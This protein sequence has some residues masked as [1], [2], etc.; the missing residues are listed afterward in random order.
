MNQG[1]HFVDLLQW[2]LGPVDTVV[3]HCVTAAHDLA[4]E[5]LCV[6][7]LTFASGALGI[8]NVSTAIYP[9]FADRLEISGTDGTAIVEAGE[10]AVWHLKAERGETGPFGET[11]RRSHR[12]EGAA[13]TRVPFTQNVAGHRAQ[14]EDLLE[15]IE[16]G[17][18]PAV[19]GQEAR[20]SLAIV[21]AIYASARSG[22]R[23][24]LASAE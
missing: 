12:D 17:R 1:I 5:D 14:L 20:K 24:T 23:V 8:V 6:A 2:L 9:G 22:E 15:A 4:V 7:Q 3:A 21:Q 11:L 13:P 10:I 16:S 19:S 18:D